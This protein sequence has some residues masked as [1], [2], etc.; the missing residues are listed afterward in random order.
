MATQRGNKTSSSSPGSMPISQFD[1]FDKEEIDC[2]GGMKGFNP[3]EDDNEK[4]ISPDYWGEVISSLYKQFWTNNKVVVAGLFIAA[5][6]AIL[7]FYVFI[8]SSFSNLIAFTSLVIS[9][10]FVLVSVG[11]L[12]WILAFPV[13]PKNMQEISDI[14]REGSEGFFMTQYGTISKFAVVTTIVIFCIY[15][16]RDINPA[17][18]LNNYFSVNGMALI[19][20]ISFALGAA[21]SAI[22]GYA[23]IW[24]SVRANIRV[25]VASRN[26]YNAAL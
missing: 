8:S 6:V 9:L 2:E 3:N 12:G 17:S 24:V 25:A 10:T 4:A 26:D 7:M 19:T 11:L 5:P 15:A 16:V 21:C 23:G 20:S 22:S 14:I 18:N 1:D 13:G